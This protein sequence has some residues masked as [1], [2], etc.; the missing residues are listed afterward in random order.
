[1]NIRKGVLHSKIK[2]SIRE[3]TINAFQDGKIRCIVATNVAS[4]GI[5]FIDVGLVINFSPP[6]HSEV[7]VHRAGRTGRAGKRGVC[8]TL[9]TR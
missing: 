3:R 7:Y 9:Y 8:I 1:M 6:N 5:D 4:R 2:Q